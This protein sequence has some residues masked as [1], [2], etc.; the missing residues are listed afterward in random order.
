MS[1][2]HNKEI[3]SEIPKKREHTPLS[4]LSV[5]RWSTRL[6]LQPTKLTLLNE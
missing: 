3:P 6:P 2:F 5:S 1:Q 4:M